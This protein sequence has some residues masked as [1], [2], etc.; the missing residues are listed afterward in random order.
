[1]RWR[2]V[3]YEVNPDPEFHD[4]PVKVMGPYT[5]ERKADKV[6]D[7]VSINMNHDRYYAVVEMAE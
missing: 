2:V 1:M 5:S 7:G 6:C 3:V 4:E